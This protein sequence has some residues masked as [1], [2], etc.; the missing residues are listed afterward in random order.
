MAKHI[1]AIGGAELGELETLPI[2]RAIRDL[3]EK[4]RPHALFIPTA[5]EDASGYVDTFAY[6]YRNHLGC[7]VDSLCIAV[8]GPDLDLTAQK[9]EWADLIYVGGGNTPK[10]VRRWREIGLDKLLRAAWM[11]GTV[12]SGLSAG[13]NCWMRFAN[14]DSPTIEGRAR[15]RFTE[16]MEGL[17][18]LDLALC[19]HMT[20]EEYR[21][22]EFLE[23]METTPGIGIGLDDGCA[24]QVRDDQFR[25]LSCVPG[26]GALLVWNSEGAVKHER[27]EA[28]ED[29]RP[30]SSL[31]RE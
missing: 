1:V 28:F 14:T 19:P 26:A 24:L 10:M 13:A 15:E 5:S 3:T 6:V 8:D 25:F 9:V 16:R 22:R 20:R 17:A 23:M 31:F 11:G 30:L 4:D 21:F 29:F 27:V 2:D 7:D 18:F 12:L